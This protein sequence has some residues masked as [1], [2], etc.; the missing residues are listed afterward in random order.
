[1]LIYNR[2]LA[3]F[4]VKAAVF[5]MLLNII[6]NYLLIKTVGLGI[7]GASIASSVSYLLVAL[8]IYFKSKREGLCI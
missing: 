7:I 6:L 4:V 3:V 1:M 2:G 5:G 8:I